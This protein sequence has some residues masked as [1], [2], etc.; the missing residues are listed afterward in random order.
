MADNTAGD[1]IQQLRDRPSVR[2]PGLG[3]IN[4]PDKP[5]LLWYAGIGAMAAVDLIEWPIAA[6]VAG[7]HFIENH[8]HNRDIQQL[9]DGI[10][11]G[12]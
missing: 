9:A 4:L 2:L 12:A 1:A 5:G 7:T 3:R 8:F 11:S 10:E 6:L